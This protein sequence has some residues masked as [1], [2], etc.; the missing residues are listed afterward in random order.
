MSAQPIESSHERET[1][2]PIDVVAVT[3][4]HDIPVRFGG[5]AASPAM[6]S[7]DMD[8]FAA[9]D[10]AEPEATALFDDA[11]DDPA[12]PFD[13]SARE[14]QPWSNALFED[15]ELMETLAAAAVAADDEGEAI[16][17]VAAIVP[18]ALRLVPDALRALTPAV[19]GLIH[20]AVRVTR[21]LHGRPAA[22]PLIGL[23]PIILR[24]TTAHLA[25]HAADGHRPTPRFA[26]RVLNWHAATVLNSR[27]G[28]RSELARRTRV[29]RQPSHA[30]SLYY[31]DY[32]D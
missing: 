1:S 22:R 24:R 4:G 30:P 15:Y 2:P 27:F 7:L 29:E 31:A 11:L 19:P 16:G 5:E 17:L 6:D 10:D 21:L 13:T 14:Q 9:S 23:V 32:R 18:L 20:G 8:D 3:R 26:A 25:Q 12:G 28:A